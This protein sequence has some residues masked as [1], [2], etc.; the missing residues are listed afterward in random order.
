MKYIKFYKKILVIGGLMSCFNAC[1]KDNYAPPTNK[2]TGRVVYQG[3]PLG[4]KNNNGGT[5]YFELWQGGYGK[6]GA[7]NVY[8]N[9]DGSFS[10]LLFNGTYK[11]VIPTSQGPFMSIENPE[12]HTDTIP[13]VLTGNKT[14]DIE[15]MPYYMINNAKFIIGAD[16]V[17]TAS[18]SVK[19]I[20]T[21]TNAKDIQFVALYVNRTD[22]VD[23]NNSFV[24]NTIAGGDISDMNNLSFTAKIPTNIAN[25]NIG[26]GKQNYFYA[27]IGLKIVGLDDM[28]F[29]DV[30]KVSL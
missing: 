25:A 10:D 2:F 29:S 15:V 28:L 11:M 18:C 6:S 20:I 26:V 13:L 7:I 30:V 1:K 12:T 22:F 17:V 16:S 23:D 4:L 21:D 8:F 19:K 5:V 3:T 24:S 9:Q 27:R 14:M